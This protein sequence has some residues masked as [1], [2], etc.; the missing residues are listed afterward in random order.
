M[1]PGTLAAILDSTCWRSSPKLQDNNGRQM[2]WMSFKP[3]LSKRIPQVSSFHDSER[4]HLSVL[5]CPKCPTMTNTC[6]DW[7]FCLGHDDTW[8]KASATTMT[9]D[10]WLNAGMKIKNRRTTFDWPVFFCVG[11]RCHLAQGFSHNNVSKCSECS[12]ESQ[13]AVS[14]PTTFDSCFWLGHAAR[15]NFLKFILIL[16]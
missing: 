5:I 4:Q 1:P 13:I 12:N 15:I 8:H 3:R 14:H 16:N 11:P 10:S 7:P 6:I 9:H 2:H